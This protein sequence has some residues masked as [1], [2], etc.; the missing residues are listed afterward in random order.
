VSN[1]LAYS[2]NVPKRSFVASVTGLQI[3]VVATV[4]FSFLLSVSFG[5]VFVEMQ[6]MKNCC[7]KIPLLIPFFYLKAI[8]LNLN[9]VSFWSQL[10]Q[11]PA[12]PDN[13]C[14]TLA[15]LGDT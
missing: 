13:T 8:Y 15:I 14:D 1:A 2:T 11:F 7:L 3:F 12:I 6:K 10:G 4:F 9:N 5:I